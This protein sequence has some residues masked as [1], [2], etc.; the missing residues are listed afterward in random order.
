[1]RAILPYGPWVG[2]LVS[3]LESIEG[4]YCTVAP[5]GTHIEA[6]LSQEDNTISRCIRLSLGLNSSDSL[7]LLEDGF[8]RAIPEAFIFCRFTTV[9]STASGG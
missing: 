5:F 9:L 2:D 1:M 3:L 6:P 8:S 7:D 4:S